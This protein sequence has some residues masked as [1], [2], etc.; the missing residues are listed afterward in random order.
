MDEKEYCFKSYK[1]ATIQ[2][3]IEK[4]GNSD[5]AIFE[6]DALVASLKIEN[7]TLRGMIDWDEEE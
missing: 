6:M 4:Y 3:N 2:K 5:D 1:K 7:D